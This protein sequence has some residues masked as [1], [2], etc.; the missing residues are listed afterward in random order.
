[1]RKLFIYSSIVM[2][3]LAG[4]G[5]NKFLEKDPDSNRAVINSP[6]QVSQL[7]V[8]AYP[9]G[10][11]VM[12]AE[13]MSDNVIDKGQGGDYIV[14]REAYMF[15][16]GSSSVDNQ[17]SPAMLWTE[18]YNAIS[19]A[20][21]ALE[22]I[23]NAPN[24]ED[25]QAQKGEALVCRAYAHFILVTFFSKF[26]DPATA[27]SDPGVPYVDEV[28][29]VVIKKYERKTVAY[30]FQ[31]IEEDLLAG[32][33]LIQ[34]K[35]YEVPR[36]HFNRAA[37]NAFASR[38]Y[39][40]KKQWDKVLQY[41]AA[42][43]PA[44][45]IADHMRPWLSWSSYDPYQIWSVYNRASTVSNLLLVETGSLFGRMYSFRYAHTNP[46]LNENW[47]IKAICGNPS[48]IF[49]SKIYTAGTLNYLVPKLGEYFVAE[50][51]NANFGQPYVMVPLF[52]TEEVLFNRMEAKIYTEDYEG[53]L[54]DMNLYVSKRAQNYNPVSNAVTEASLMAYAGN[55]ADKKDAYIKGMLGLKRMEYL[56]QG[57][58]W[59]DMQRYKIPVS[60]PVYST[61]GTLIETIEIGPDDPR[62]VLQLPNTATLAGLELNPR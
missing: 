5:C 25:Y 24:P 26:Y 60:H 50:S 2:V 47:A 39:L 57:L 34:D 19:S 29:D 1:M 46:K 55:P 4:S 14:N 43:F 33:P 6:E 32:L 58:R 61:S 17:D 27:D 35:Y 42:A 10:G 16:E 12:L 51:V 22:A 56:M 28:E 52:D 36:Y 54:A 62:R 8:S 37:A 53:A 11:Y 45:N 20:N 31:R 7:L 13:C 18:A 21:H 15:Q 48:W 44:G 41:A 40:V 30:V 23:K 59:F 9:K 49:Q 38:F 3:G